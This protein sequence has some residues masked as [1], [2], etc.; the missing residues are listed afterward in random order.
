ME[1]LAQIIKEILDGTAREN[2][3]NV[4]G[5]SLVGDFLAI[6]ID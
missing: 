2:G 4:S 5:R 6:K 3:A 1:Q